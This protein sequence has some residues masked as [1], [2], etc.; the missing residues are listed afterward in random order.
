MQTYNSYAT[1]IKLIMHMYR[2]K[3]ATSFMFK[4][5]SLTY[6]KMAKIGQSIMKNFINNLSNITAQFSF[7][8]DFH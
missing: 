8:T 1:N 4:K 7:P 5:L 3:Y 2:L 6:E